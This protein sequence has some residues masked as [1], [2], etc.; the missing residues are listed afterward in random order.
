M[1]YSSVRELY[2]KYDVYLKDNAELL[3]TKAEDRDRYRKQYE[4][5]RST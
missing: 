4:V 3:K 1:M 2:E 5:I